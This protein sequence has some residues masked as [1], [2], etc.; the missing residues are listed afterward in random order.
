MSQRNKRLYRIAAIVRSSVSSIGRIL[1]PIRAW[2]R[3]HITSFL[4]LLGIISVLILTL[5]SIRGALFPSEIRYNRPLLIF[6]IIAAVAGM[7]LSIIPREKYQ[8]IFANTFGWLPVV[9]G[10]I[11]WP[12]W[13]WYGTWHPPVLA[14]ADF[15][16]TAAQVLPVLLLAAVIDVRRSSTL[17][18]SQL[19]LP[20]IV[21]FLGEIDALGVLA[22][23][24]TNATTEF[25]SVSASFT[26]TIIAL[27]LAVL[28]DIAIPKRNTRSSRKSKTFIAAQRVKSYGHN[29]SGS[30]TKPS[31]ED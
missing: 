10:A 22:F 27:L 24:Q 31:Q 13:Y 26:S 21:V 20:V 1:L 29:R 25:A 3:R 23:P 8:A 2:S 18:S 11:S 28:A 12:Y 14:H 6:T 9:L 7:I 17:K 15:F 16:A 4:M 30:A 5:L 19:V